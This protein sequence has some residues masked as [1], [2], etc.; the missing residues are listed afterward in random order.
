MRPASDLLGVGARQHIGN[1][2]K[3]DAEAR[4]LGDAQHAAD[5]LLA[6]KRG[7]VTLAW[8]EAVVAAIAALTTLLVGPVFA[9]IAEQLNASAFCAVGE[10]RHAV[11]LGA[12]RPPR[13]L[14]LDL[15]DESDV[16]GDIAARVEQQALA[17]QTVAARAA[18][19]LV[20]ALDIL[21]KIGVDDEAHIGLVDAHAESDRRAD[22][23]NFVAQKRILIA[24]ARFGIEP[25]VVGRRRHARPHQRR[26]HRLGR[27]ARL[28]VDDAGVVVFADAL[29]RNMLARNM[30]A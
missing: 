16:L 30:L 28:A 25:S 10:R 1:M 20:V 2:L 6:L 5:E 13:I 22:H 17:G 7:V 12:R 11:E 14:V 29:A 3:P 19:L 18:S 21:G 23:A 15:A 26:R 27:L 4:H 9:E 8:F 24:R